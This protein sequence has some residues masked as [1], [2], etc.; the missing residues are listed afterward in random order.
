MFTTHNVK[1]GLI[2]LYCRYPARANTTSSH[3]PSDLPPHFSCHVETTA[4]AALRSLTAF[5]LPATTNLNFSLA[6]RC[7]GATALRLG[8]E[9]ERASP[10]EEFRPTC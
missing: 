9:Q 4:E 6:E 1:L 7:L 5:L 10:A 3:I 2:K 8:G